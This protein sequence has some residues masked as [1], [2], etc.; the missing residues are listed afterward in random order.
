MAQLHEMCTTRMASRALPAPVQPSA[1]DVAV[2]DGALW[3]A[4]DTLLYAYSPP[5]FEQTNCVDLGNHVAVKIASACGMLWA[6]SKTS[7]EGMLTLCCIDTQSGVNET[8]YTVSNTEPAMSG[9]A[10]RLVLSVGNEVWVFQPTKSRPKGR[11]DKT[12]LLHLDHFVLC[13]TFLID[14]W[15]TTPHSILRA[16]CNMRSPWVTHAAVATPWGFAWSGWNSNTFHIDNVV[17]DGTTFRCDCKYSSGLCEWDSRV[18]KA[19]LPP[20][21]VDRPAF[22]ATDLLYHD[23]QTR[24]AFRHLRIGADATSLAWLAPNL[25]AVQGGQLRCWTPKLLAACGAR[26]GCLEALD[27]NVLDKMYKY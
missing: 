27:P 7:A 1:A 10:E 6:L 26:V 25:W 9:C 19:V 21:S 14:V 13:S 15:K 20:P 16:A 17:F 22:V 12:G 2:H 18:T 4:S 3:V 24:C 8:L 5:A 23:P 11:A